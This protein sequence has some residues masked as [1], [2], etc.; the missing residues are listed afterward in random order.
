MSTPKSPEELRTLAY[1]GVFQ[2]SGAV[3][4]AVSGGVTGGEDELSQLPRRAADQVMNMAARRLAFQLLYE[5]DQKRPGDADAAMVVRD[6]LKGVRD[7][8]PVAAEVVSELVLGAWSARSAADAEYRELAPEWPTHRQAAVDR[9]LLRLA[10]FEMS[11][12]RNPAKVVVNET[13]ELAKHFSTEKAPGFIN[14]L[15]DKVMK[16]VESRPNL[17]SGG[18]APGEAAQG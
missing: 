1:T 9:A 16:R 15:L 13:V 3:E 18:E 4:G 8:G 7:L 5:L 14:A 17:A 2:L 11:S 6:A 10:H 12:G